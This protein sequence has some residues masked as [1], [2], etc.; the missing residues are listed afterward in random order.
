MNERVVTG[1]RLHSRT[2]R[3][4]RVVELPNELRVA[5]EPFG[6]GDIFDAMAFPQ[7]VAVA[8]RGHAAF[9]GYPGPGQHAYAFRR[10]EN[11]G[12]LIER[13]VQFFLSHGQP[14]AA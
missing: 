11:V 8:E 4:A 10:A 1:V 2:V 12:G 9:C 13:V 7:S 6:A 3:A 5:L 14:P